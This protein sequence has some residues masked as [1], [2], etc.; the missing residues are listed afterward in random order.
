MPPALVALVLAAGVALSAC[1]ESREA[2]AEPTWREVEPIL[3]GECSHC[4]GASAKTTGGGF[5]FDFYE[6][7]KETCGDAVEALGVDTPMAKALAPQLA[8]AITSDYTSVRPSM[9]PLPAE[10]LEE[11]QWQTI[12]RWADKPQRGVRGSDNT[13]PSILVNQLSAKA[14]K[15]MDVAV[16]LED[17]DGDPVIGVLTIGDQSFKM[18]RSG[19]FNTRAD[20]STWEPGD[21]KVGVVLCDGLSSVSY[22][23]GTVN[24]THL[25]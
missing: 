17:R 13:P 24:V 14:D 6:M 9:P 18:D 25:K 5:R 20:T 1:A 7:T 16:S 10:Y 2:P 3:R 4:H 15:F 19:S 8:K 12:L 22:M 21:R 23:L 11:W